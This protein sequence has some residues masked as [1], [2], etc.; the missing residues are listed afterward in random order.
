HPGQSVGGGA[1][2]EKPNKKTPGNNFNTPRQTPKSGPRGHAANPVGVQKNV[3]VKKILNA[4]HLSNIKK[5]QKNKT[6]KYNRMR[7]CGF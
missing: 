6:A 3:N 5:K 2:T 7:S 1:P 4:K